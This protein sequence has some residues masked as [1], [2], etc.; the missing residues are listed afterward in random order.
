M[1]NQLESHKRAC[2]NKNV[3]NAIIPSERTKTFE[4]NICQKSEKAPPI[5]YVECLIEKIDG[6]KKILKIHPQQK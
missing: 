5:T 1:K 4:I 3:C 6:C 2:E